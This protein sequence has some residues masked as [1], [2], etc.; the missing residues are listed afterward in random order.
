MNW[1]LEVDYKKGVVVPKSAV[2]KELDRRI[3]METVHPPAEQG[4]LLHRCCG[5]GAPLIFV[6]FRDSVPA[7]LKAMSCCGTSLESKTSH[8]YIMQKSRRERLLIAAAAL[9]WG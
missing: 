7:L 8:R 3:G 4:S 9:R 6:I 5:A 1:D 2:D